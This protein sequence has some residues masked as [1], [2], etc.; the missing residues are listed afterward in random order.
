MPKCSLVIKNN[1]FMEKNNKFVKIKLPKIETF[2][3]GPR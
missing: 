3:P 2:Y 1:P